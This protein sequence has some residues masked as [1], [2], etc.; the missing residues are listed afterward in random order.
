MLEEYGG[1]GA[2][3]ARYGIA[4]GAA[5]ADDA[6]TA[7]LADSWSYDGNAAC[8]ATAE[9]VVSRV[10]AV[11]SAVVEVVVVVVVTCVG[12]CVGACVGV[13][14]GGM[15]GSAEGEVLRKTCTKLPVPWFESG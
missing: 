8:A 11:R 9:V 12:A 4:C 10:V 3:P 13:G 14:V 2:V 6:V 1:G 15:G 5:G 7:T